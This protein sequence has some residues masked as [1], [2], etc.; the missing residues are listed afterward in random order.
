MAVHP[1]VGD[2]GEDALRPTPSGMAR[3]KKMLSDDAAS[4]A[5]EANRQRSRERG[6]AIMRVDDVQSPLPQQST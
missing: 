3:R 4:P 6:A 1:P 5:G 2:S